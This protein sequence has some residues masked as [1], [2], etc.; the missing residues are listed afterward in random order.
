MSLCVVLAH[1]LLP[2]VVSCAYCVTASRILKSVLRWAS[3]RDSGRLRA[4]IGEGKVSLPIRA[5]SSD[6]PDS[7]PDDIL[8][9]HISESE[10]PKDNFESG[11]YRGML[12]VC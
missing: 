10:G 7:R 4:S 5:G 6:A 2:E 12:S 8:L 3:R 1:L 9:V 11:A